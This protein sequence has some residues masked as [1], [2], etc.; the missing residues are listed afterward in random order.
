MLLR[1]LP[2]TLRSS[3]RPAR[4]E[5]RSSLLTQSTQTSA[6][7]S[8]EFCLVLFR[9]MFMVVI[10]CLSGPRSVQDSRCE[11]R[12]SAQG[13]G[14]HLRYQPRQ[15]EQASLVTRV[16]WPGLCPAHSDSI[17]HRHF[18][19]QPRKGCFEIRVGE[20]KVLSLLVR[21][22]GTVFP[23]RAAGPEPTD[24]SRGQP[25]ET[26]GRTRHTVRPAVPL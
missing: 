23:V 7:L 4:A 8:P 6:A 18:I 14:Y 26:A 1:P 13:Q 3:S 9:G 5:V 22:R 12:V 11:A 16:D 21:W 10:L 19:L 2:P 25:W 24:S 17:R 15:G 20:K